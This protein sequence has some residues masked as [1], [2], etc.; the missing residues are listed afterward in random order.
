VRLD[1]KDFQFLYAE[2]DDLV[3]MDK[4]TYEQIT[5]LPTCWA[6]P[7]PSCRTA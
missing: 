3:F 4:D 1:T 7:P 6:M 2:G 5:C